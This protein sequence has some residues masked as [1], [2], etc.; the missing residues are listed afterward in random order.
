[1]KNLLLIDT[2]NLKKS[3]KDSSNFIDK[4]NLVIRNINGKWPL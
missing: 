4:L 3:Y 1:M 2:E